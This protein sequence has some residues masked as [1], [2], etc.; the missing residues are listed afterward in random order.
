MIIGGQSCASVFL[1]SYSQAVGSTPI[2]PP[3][4]TT[5]LLRGNWE[6]LL[7]YPN[8]TWI[9]ENNQ[10]TR[11][12]KEPTMHAFIQKLHCIGSKIEI[13][14]EIGLCYDL[15]MSYSIVALVT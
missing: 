15:P 2:V 4:T 5:F 6:S 11:S 13:L 3:N 10:R 7:K 14:K 9:S 8:E 12:R 1:D